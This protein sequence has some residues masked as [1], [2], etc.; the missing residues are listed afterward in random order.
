MSRG[1]LKVM[2]TIALCVYLIVA[3]AA[4]ALR[5]PWMTD[6]ERFLYIGRALTFGRVEY[7]EARP[8]E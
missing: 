3:N 4:F 1:E 5:H 8:R 2:A 6:T 7:S